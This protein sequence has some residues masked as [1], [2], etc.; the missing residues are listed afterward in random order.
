M[1]VRTAFSCSMLMVDDAILDYVVPPSEEVLL[2]ES[3]PPPDAGPDWRTEI[4]STLDLQ[5]LPI[6]S[7]RKLPL[8]YK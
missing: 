4:R 3:T 7:E 6:F 2:E 8:V 5:P 1:S